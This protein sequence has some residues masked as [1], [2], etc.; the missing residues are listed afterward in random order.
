MDR[1]GYSGTKKLRGGGA[2]TIE[3][4]SSGARAIHTR[5]DL[6]FFVLRLEGGDS[7]GSYKHDALEN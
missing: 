6:P 5:V 7:L 4:L 2:A 1:C 3:L